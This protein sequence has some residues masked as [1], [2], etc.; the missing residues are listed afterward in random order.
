MKLMK[1]TI[2]RKVEFKKSL[3]L[4]FQFETCGEELKELDARNN[5]Y[6]IMQQTLRIT[7]EELK[8]RGEYDG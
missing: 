3:T 7:S 4:S 8:S 5:F 6:E 2:S 1:A